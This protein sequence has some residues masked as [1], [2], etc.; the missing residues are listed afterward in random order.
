[1][2]FNWSLVFVVW[3]VRRCGVF[4]VQQTVFSVEGVNLC[5]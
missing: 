5:A 1:M 4:D 2:S 3:C